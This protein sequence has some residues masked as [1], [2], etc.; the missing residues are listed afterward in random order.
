MGYPTYD[1]T[2]SKRFHFYLHRYT[3]FFERL[4][5]RI[6]SARPSVALL[7]ARFCP[8]YRLT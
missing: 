3:N 6:P 1:A 8:T 5:N 7:P 2:K 4:P